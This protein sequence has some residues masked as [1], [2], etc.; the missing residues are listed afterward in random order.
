MCVCTLLFKVEN[1][2]AEVMVKVK[3]SKVWFFPKFAAAHL[4]GIFGS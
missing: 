4:F 1:G 2:K 3:H